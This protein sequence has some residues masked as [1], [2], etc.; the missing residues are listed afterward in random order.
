MLASLTFRLLHLPWRAKQKPQL[1][2]NYILPHTINRLLSILVHTDYR[3]HGLAQQ[4]IL[5]L[6]QNCLRLSLTRLGLSVKSC[7]V[8]AVR[9]Y[10]K[11]GYSPTVNL[12]GSIN[13]DFVMNQQSFLDKHF[14]LNTDR[15]PSFFHVLKSVTMKFLK[16]LILLNLMANYGLWLFPLRE[17]F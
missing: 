15:P 17:V 6:E 4:L 5:A 16:L 8:P 7:N 13:I 10:Q 1:Q 3:S 9:L 11:L 12:S 2:V 14:V